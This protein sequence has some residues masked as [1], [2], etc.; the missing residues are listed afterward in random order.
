V[1]SKSQC[2][3]QFACS[4]WTAE[5]QGVGNAL[6]AYHLPQMLFGGFL[7]DYVTIEHLYS[8][9]PNLCSSFFNPNQ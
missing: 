2:Q 5:H 6:F 1:G 4:L 9:I 8:L 7:S 3:G